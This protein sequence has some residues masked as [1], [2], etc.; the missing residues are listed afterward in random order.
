MTNLRRAI[1]R[2]EFSGA[3]TDNFTFN[4]TKYPALTTEYVD[5]IGGDATVEIDQAFNSIAIS[6]LS[7]NTVRFYAG[8]D[9]DDSIDLATP[10]TPN[11]FDTI[12]V[13]AG[14]SIAFD[15][16][17]T[18]NRLRVYSSGA[19]TVEITLEVTN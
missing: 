11:A 12:E 3:G 18:I 16:L 1:I 15:D 7:G 17:R 8:D 2:H 19:G 9:A 6:E 4:R 10:D 13:P 14:S 5:Y